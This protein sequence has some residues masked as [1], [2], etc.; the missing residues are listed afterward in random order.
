MTPMR[1][2]L[3]FVCTWWAVLPAWWALSVLPMSACAEASASASASAPRWREG[4]AQALPDMPES[5]RAAFFRGRSLFRQNW[6]QPPSD[7]PATGLGPLYNRLS[8][9]A[10]HTHN[11][12]GDAPPENG[13]LQGA[14]VR[15]SVPGKGAHGAPRPH[16]VYGDQFNEEGV[17][18]VP[19]EGR[20]RVHWR[21]SVLYLPDGERVAM[22]QPEL[23]FQDLAYGPLSPTTA[24]PSAV[25]TLRSLRVGQPVFGLG[26][27][28]AVA[29]ETL[30]ELARTPHLDH[31][32]GQPNRVWQAATR[33]TVLGRFGWKA[34]MASLDEQ[35]EGAMV[36]D[37]GVTTPLHPHE[38]CTSLQSACLKQATQ[39]EPELHKD[40]LQD[41]L[42]YLRWLA[43]PAPRHSDAV[44]AAQGT[45]LFH[46]LGC[47]ACHLPSVKTSTTA[48]FPTLA[49]RTIHP[50]TDL[51][52]HDMGE[53]LAD[54]RPDFRASGRQWR[55]PALWGIGLAQ[56]INAQAAYLHDGRARTLQEAVLWHGGE[57]DLA[58]QRYARLPRDQRQVLLDYLSGL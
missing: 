5:D 38:A 22:R 43:P 25:A 55:T 39:G 49:P 50:Y 29:D 8:C 27:L 6:V 56:L 45:A 11:G 58:R 3:L 2:P 48:A 44:R 28:S 10:C 51:L 36:G 26:L 19:G 17:P 13:R 34:N 46:H 32:H 57:A 21:T 20:V 31:V 18:G 30:F 12:R 54:H 35:I 41:L 15:L 9:V 4:Y 23:L 24:A 14:L 16:P 7:D 53:G 40:Q 47:A 33:T 42:T 1:L 52:L 37:L